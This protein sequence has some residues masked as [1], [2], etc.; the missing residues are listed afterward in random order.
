MFCSTPLLYMHT[1]LVPFMYFS[2]KDN[3]VYSQMIQ[4]SCKRPKNNIKHNPM[5]EFYTNMTLLPLEGVNWEHSYGWF[6]LT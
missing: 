5:L 2:L 1:E 6:R 3:I 4:I